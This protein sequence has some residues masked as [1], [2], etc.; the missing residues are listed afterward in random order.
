MFSSSNGVISTSIYIYIKKLDTIEPK[1][2][3]T[4][5]SQ[6]VQSFKH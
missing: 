5:M 3:Q 2:D 4:K 6:V 1:E